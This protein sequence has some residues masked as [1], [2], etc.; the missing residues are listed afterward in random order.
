[1]TER[2]AMTRR[3]STSR[4]VQ[5]LSSDSI[6]SD[7]IAAT[8]MALSRDGSG[9]GGS[10]IRIAHELVNTPPVEDSYEDSWPL[11]AAK[12]IGLR[13]VKAAVTKALQNA[14][15]ETKYSLPHPGETI[16]WRSNS[17]VRSKCAMRRGTTPRRVPP[18]SIWW[19]GRAAIAR[20]NGRG[21]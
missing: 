14:R 17:A 3:K 6:R 18:R 10:E 11:A 2:T 20:R 9:E 7:E 19:F 15:D 13:Q 8:D 12:S 1:M 4:R 21:G 5:T 16:T